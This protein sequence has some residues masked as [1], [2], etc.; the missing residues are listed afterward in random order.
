MPRT[1]TSAAVAKQVGSALRQARTSQD[2]TQAEVARR[3]N[4]SASYIANLEAGRENPTVGQLAN[5]AAGVGG[6][7]DIRF[8][9]FE[10]ERISLRQQS[11]R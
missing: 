3:L 7:I 11:T 1:T 9:F 4:V 6:V 2:M 8:A 5:L 10:R